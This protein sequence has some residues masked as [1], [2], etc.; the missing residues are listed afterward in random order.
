VVR[1]RIAPLLAILLAGC[2]TVG[3]DYHV[4]DAAIV[5]APTAQGA[6]A[7]GTAVTS[8]Q[9][10]PDHWWTLF[11]DP[12][13]DGL[14]VR[15]LDANTDLRVA[16]A[17]LAR[18]YALLD[19]RGAS[20]ELQGSLAADTSYAQR[21]AEAEL[22]HVQPPTRQIY[23]AGITASYDL[24]LFGGLRRGI[25]AASADTEA[26]IAARDLARVNVAAETTRA[27]MDIC[28]AGFQRDVLDRSIALQGRGIALTRTLIRY[29]RAVSFDR[30]RRQ[31]ALDA[32]RA[33]RPRIVAR[34]DNALLRLTALL[35]KTPAE[36]DKNLLACH[37]PL[38]LARLV[39]VGDGQALLRRRPDIRIAERRLAA[40]TA[41]IGVETAQLYPDI[42][43]GASLGST[44]AAADALSPLTNRFGIG[45]S[46]SWAV[47]RHAVRARIDAA[48]AQSRVELA[49]FDG[50]VLKALREVE[51]ALNSYAA[52]IEQQ[53][54][55]EQARAAAARVAQQTA[56]LRRG[57]KIAELPAI[58][59]ERD[60]VIAEQAAADG[61]VAMSEDQIALFL[62][63]GGGWTPVATTARRQ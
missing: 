41:R 49:T 57:G 58:E 30:D 43:F 6:F 17:S 50:V 62:A 38:D 32:S 46:I 40:A 42:R 14:V 54:S 21:S 52:G 26:A 61:R 39:P 19:A 23:N 2:T 11:N 56:R 27:Y 29:G 53:Q 5:R 25:E 45:P 16:E 55:L 1:P 36:A 10:L 31:G 13:L 18:S 34:Q 33:R 3:P 15:A 51:S 12:V 20:R 8:S 7:G 47:N 37:H 44:G 9:P 35:G 63:L 4:P 24:D 22:S 59:A 28:N 48:Q 60:L